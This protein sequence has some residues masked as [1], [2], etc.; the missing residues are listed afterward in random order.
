VRAGK[1]L[2]FPSRRGSMDEL[3]IGKQISCPQAAFG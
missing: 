2:G 1:G 3:V